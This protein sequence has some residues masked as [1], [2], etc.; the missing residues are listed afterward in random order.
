M[1]AVFRDEKPSPPDGG[2]GRMRPTVG[3]GGF[4]A[5]FGCFQG[6]AAERG[7]KTERFVLISPPSPTVGRMRPT[8]PSGGE[9]FV[10]GAG[11]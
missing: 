2:V 10:G 1:S 8:P 3:E 11:P 4:V 6:G 5:W 7:V 9:G